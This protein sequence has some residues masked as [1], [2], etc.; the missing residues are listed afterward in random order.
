MGDRYKNYAFM[1][2]EN[3]NIFEDRR[4]KWYY[5]QFGNLLTKMTTDARIWSKTYYD[6]NSSDA[7][8]PANYIN[9][10]ITWEGRV[11]FVDGI[12]EA[13]ESTDNWAISIVGV[14]ALGTKF[15][16]LTLNCPNILGIKADFQPTT[17]EASIVNSIIAG[18]E[19]SAAGVP[20]EH[21][22]VE[23]GFH[24]LFLKEGQ[25]RRKFGALTLGASYVNIYNAQT[26]HEK[27]DTWKGTVHDY[28]P[29]PILY[30]LR[31][32]DDSP[33]DGNGQIINDVK[34]K[35]DGIHR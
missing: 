29:T 30:A 4:N 19:S 24:V 27:G 21:F 1:G 34:L 7:Y 31:I 15:T 5:N 18:K 2:F 23:K 3:Y 33:H 32:M 6:D 13:R 9:I 8:P 22:G 14:G 16:P 17:F 20:G 28:M 26:N 35:I 25:L 10:Q 11:R 12:W